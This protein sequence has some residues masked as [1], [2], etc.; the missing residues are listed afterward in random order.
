MINSYTSQ[1][2]NLD[3]N[4]NE[5]ENEAELENEKLFS[6]WYICCIV[7]PIPF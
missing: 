2:S 6:T 1:T 7:S 5:S 4:D 3:G